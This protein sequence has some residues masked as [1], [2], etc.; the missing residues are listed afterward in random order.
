MIMNNIQSIIEKVRKLLALATSQNVNE[1]ANAAAKAN[2]LIDEY[3]LS[4][5]QLGASS[6]DAD[7][8]LIHDEAEPLF[9]SDRSMAWR[10]TLALKLS[11]H[12]GCYVWNKKSKRNIFYVVAGRQSDI[13]VL[14]YMFAY[15]SSECMRLSTAHS[16]G[17]GRNYAESYRL[18]FVAGVTS[19]LA[20][21][22]QQAVQAQTVTDASIALVKL[23]ERSKAARDLVKKTVTLGK[24][25]AQ[26]ANHTNP[27]AY[28]SGQSAGRNTHLGANLGAGR[29]MALK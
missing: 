5:D 26:S 6:S 15:L 4:V 1:A 29:T 22:R 3:R 27:D 28:Y 20:E 17:K 23:D 11:Q 25:R 16:K 24:S 13:T 2:E 8:P 21:S 12:Y 7:D 9:E 19:A 18:G 14:R 10:K